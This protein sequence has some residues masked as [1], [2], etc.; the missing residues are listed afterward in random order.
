VGVFISVVQQQKKVL[1]EQELL[2]QVSYVE[3]H[4]SKAIRMAKTET[5]ENCLVDSTG[6]DH[7]GFIY[8]LTHYDTSSGSYRGIKFI[9]QSDNN[10]CYEF[11]FGADGILK[12]I[13][14]NG[15]PIALTSSDTSSGLK[16]NSFQFAIEG[17]QTPLS[18]SCP[19]PPVVCGA[20]SEDAIQPRVTMFLNTSVANGS[21]NIIQTT[22]SQRNLNVP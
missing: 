20:S 8:L 11:F 14:G 21:P 16:V 2:N 22:V 7:P 19:S 10:T 4:M 12:E 5:T 1:S 6:V 3:E 15:P 9:N 18:L 17:F 13:K